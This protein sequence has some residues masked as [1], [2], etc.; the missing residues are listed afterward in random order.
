[1]PE[2]S[3]SAASAGGLLHAA[4]RPSNSAPRR[5]FPVSPSL[6]VSMSLSLSLSLSLLCCLCSCNPHAPPPPLVCWTAIQLFNHSPETNQHLFGGRPR[7]WSPPLLP[8]CCQH[9]SRR[10]LNPSLPRPRRGLRTMPAKH[11]AA[12]RI[13]CSLSQTVV[14][15]A[16]KYLK[17]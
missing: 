3:L 1:V 12:Q 14:G 17:T 8:S 6:S 2:A 7:P 16:S 15:A 11:S 10:Q 9:A 13:A 5:W 4:Y